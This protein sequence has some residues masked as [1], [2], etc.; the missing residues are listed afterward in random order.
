MFAS[1][2]ASPS[3]IENNP[4]TLTKDLPNEMNETSGPEL[5]LLLVSHANSKTMKYDN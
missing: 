3:P 4:K 5:N 2:P 1:D